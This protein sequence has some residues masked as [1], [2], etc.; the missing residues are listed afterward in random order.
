MRDEFLCLHMSIRLSLVNFHFRQVMPCDLQVPL[1]I[2]GGPIQLS[3]VPGHH[4]VPLNLGDVVDLVLLNL[5]ANA[6]SAH[7]FP[8]SRSCGR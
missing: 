1:F 5:P 6:N 8:F 3:P 4:I 7:P 2:E